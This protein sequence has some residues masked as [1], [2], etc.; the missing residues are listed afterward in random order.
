VIRPI[1][2]VPDPRLLQVS[3]PTG[4]LDKERRKI[5]QD[6]LDTMR[7]AKGYGLSAVQIGVLV[8]ICAINPRCGFPFMVLI[9][10][11]ITER[12]AHHVMT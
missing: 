8:R 5:A 7:H 11:V 2:S 6:L 3:E 4:V 12:A 1:L 9:N 10:P